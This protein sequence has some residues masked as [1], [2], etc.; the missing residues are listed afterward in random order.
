[1]RAPTGGFNR[2]RALLGSIDFELRSA[3]RRLSSS[4][5]ASLSSP[6]SDSQQAGP[7]SSRVAIHEES[8]TVLPGAGRRGEQHEA[9][10]DALVQGVESR[11]RLNQVARGSAGP[12]AWW[13]Q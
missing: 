3:L 7:G 1:M 9:L 8:S 11:S 12:A 5:F 4:R 6:S 10:A 13:P 2:P